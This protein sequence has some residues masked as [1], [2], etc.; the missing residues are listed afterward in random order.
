MCRLRVHLAAIQLAFNDTALRQTSPSS[1]L[2]QNLPR[3]NIAIA[4]A[5]T[6]CTDGS[7]RSSAQRV[8]LRLLGR[9][10]F[11]HNAKAANSTELHEKKIR[12]RFK[13][14]TKD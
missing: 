3:F 12:V 14:R 7:A 8:R 10:L 5:V 2:M 9:E 1:C 13:E 6:G 11:L 4:M